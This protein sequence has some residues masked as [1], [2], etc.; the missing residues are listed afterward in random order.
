MKTLRGLAIVLSLT[1]HGGMVA[2]M[3][4]WDRASQNSFD[5]G[6]GS[7]A[8]NLDSAIS[9]TA[10]ASFGAATETIRAT[11]AEDLP[12]QVAQAAAEEVKPKDELETVIASRS[13]TATEVAAVEE[14]KPVEQPQPKQIEVQEQVQ[15]VA[16][17]EQ[18]AASGKSVA[19]SNPGAIAAYK[20]ELWK[21]ISKNQVV[22]NTQ[23]A[24]TVKVSFRLTPG[25]DLLEW[26]IVEST[27]SKVHEDA[28]VKAL[29]KTA[30]F[31]PLPSALAGYN[32]PFEIEFRYRLQ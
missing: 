27:G 20:G 21:A 5:V 26:R 11:E 22:P 25:G 30:P 6:S 9:I 16:A 1:L 17:V 4:K 18:L 23:R 32:D 12:T 28:T 10:P 14:V 31:P 3:M 13:E 24:A 15:Q 8:F 29:K 19:S 7:D 2:A